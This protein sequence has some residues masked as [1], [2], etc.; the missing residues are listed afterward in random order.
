MHED[1]TA[2]KISK[3]VSSISVIKRFAL[4]K[5]YFYN[6]NRE[7]LSHIILSEEGYRSLFLLPFNLI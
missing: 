5:I 1:D 4:V 6:S 3:K 7:E 2:N